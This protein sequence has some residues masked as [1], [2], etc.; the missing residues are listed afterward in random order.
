MRDD[1]WSVVCRLK[2][3]R[4]F[5]GHTVRPHR[6]DLDAALASRHAVPEEAHPTRVCPLRARR[7]DGR[8]LRLTRGGLRRLD[9]APPRSAARRDGKVGNHRH[10]E[11][12]T[13]TALAV[14]Y[15]QRPGGWGW[16]PLGVEPPPLPACTVLPRRWGETPDRLD[17]SMS[18]PEQ[19][20][21]VPP[22]EP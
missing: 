15:Q 5:N 6:R 17:R 12:L 22:G 7:R 21:G 8:A 13:P 20:L 1:G 18:P 11:R 4:R 14:G 3:K 10:D 16:H 9:A 19:R 2:K